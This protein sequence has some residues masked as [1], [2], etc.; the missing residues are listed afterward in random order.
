MTEKFEK[1]KQKFIDDWEKIFRVKCNSHDIEHNIF[2]V[3]V[4]Y[5]SESFLIYGIFS[6]DEFVPLYK[7]D[8]FITK[9]NGFPNPSKIFIFSNKNIF[10]NSKDFLKWGDK[11]IHLGDGDKPVKRYIKLTNVGEFEYQGVKYFNVGHVDIYEHE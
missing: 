4:K 2:L 5:G 7:F 3:E 10:E 1:F 11:E 9:F 8:K 6:F